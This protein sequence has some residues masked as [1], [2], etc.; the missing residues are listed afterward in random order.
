MDLK[1]G[2]ADATK[3]TNVRPG[4]ASAACGTAVPSTS[5]VFVISEVQDALEQ[6]SLVL[7]PV[8]DPSRISIASV[9]LPSHIHDL[10]RDLQSMQVEAGL[11]DAGDIIEKVCALG[12]ELS[13][14]L[15]V[16][17]S[18]GAR[19]KAE[20]QERIAKAASLE[21]RDAQI[22]ELGVQG[23]KQQCEKQAEHLRD[24]Q[25]KAFGRY[26]RLATMLKCDPAKIAQCVSYLQLEHLIQTTQKGHGEVMNEQKLQRVIMGMRYKLL[27]WRAKGHI[28]AHEGDDQWRASHSRVFHEYRISPE[29]LEQDMEAVLDA[30]T[31]LS[32][33]LYPLYR[34]LPDPT[35]TGYRVPLPPSA[36]GLADMMVELMQGGSVHALDL[37]A[38]H[39]L[40]IS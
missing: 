2:T 33:R 26:K 22:A 23:F 1:A 27:I 4:T 31:L 14:E 9:Q 28:K 38:L 35:F 20:G 19:A 39:S 16:W 18:R 29:Q 6:A 17:L 34:V 24:Y 30:L 36:E 8:L 21:L 25:A 15:E 5:S 7:G 12:D 32:A 37:E 13:S 40:C 11:S 10:L 3:A